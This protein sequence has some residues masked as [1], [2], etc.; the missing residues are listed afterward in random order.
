MLHP[1]D[2]RPCSTRLRPSICRSTQRRPK[3]PPHGNETHTLPCQ[4]ACLWGLCVQS[5]KQTRDH[6]SRLASIGKCRRYRL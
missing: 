2:H 6:P 5:R 3:R 4:S 1:A